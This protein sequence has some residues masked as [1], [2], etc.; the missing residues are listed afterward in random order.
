MSATYETKGRPL[1]DF[2]YV[3]EIDIRLADLKELSEPETWDYQFTTSDRPNPILYFYF[4]YTFERVKE[5]DKIA[6]S[7]DKS[8]CCFNT[9]LVTTNQATIRLIL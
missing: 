2:A 5:Q 4:H 6:L 7:S 8:F 3:H 1:Y 9:G